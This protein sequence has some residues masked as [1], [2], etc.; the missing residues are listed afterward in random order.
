M[1]AR[2]RFA[3]ARR[4]GTLTAARARSLCRAAT[5][6]TRFKNDGDVVVTPISDLQNNGS[7]SR[8]GRQ[9]GRQRRI[10][11][12]ISARGIDGGAGHNWIATTEP[13]T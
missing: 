9:R 4:R 2:L 13:S 11:V 12:H 6:T 3:G 8:A 1:T 10:G 7:V 5:A